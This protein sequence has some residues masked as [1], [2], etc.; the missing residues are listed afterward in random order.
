M[1]LDMQPHRDF[2]GKGFFP[3]ERPAKEIKD[4]FGDIL[5]MGRNPSFPPYDVKL[6]DKGYQIDIAVAGFAREDLDVYVDDSVLVIEG[7]RDNE[8]DKKEKFLHKGIAKR[9]FKL[10]FKLSDTLEVGY[11]KMSNGL[12]T[13][14]IDRKERKEEDVKRIEIE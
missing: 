4:V 5:E 1:W 3:N 7:R 12:L 6:T 10:R 13:I 9:K 2:P 11:S 14:D 8:A